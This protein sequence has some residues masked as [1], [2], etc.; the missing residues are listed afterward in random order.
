MAALRP[1]LRTCLSCRA[2]LRDAREVPARVAALA[3]VGLLAG[4]H[5]PAARSVLDWL[6]E[7]MTWLALRGQ[8]VIETASSHKLAAAAAS[9]AALGG[10]GIATVEVS[11]HHARPP[12]HHRHHARREVARYV[13]AAPRW[14]PPRATAP[15]QPAPPPRRRKRHRHAVP[16]AQAPVIENAAPAPAPAPPPAPKAARSPEPQTGEFGP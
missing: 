10:G 2:A 7:R 1:H 9:A 15:V 4:G 3:P 8:D 5:A 11:H 16:Q 12:A 6:N 14:R 13:P